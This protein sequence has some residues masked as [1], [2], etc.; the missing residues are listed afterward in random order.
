M[1]ILL[2]PRIVSIDEWYGY[3]FE[4]AYEKEGEFVHVYRVWNCRNQ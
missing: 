1:D 4:I 2:S 3:R